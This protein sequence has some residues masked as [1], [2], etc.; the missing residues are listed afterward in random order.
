MKQLK[1]WNKIKDWCDENNPVSRLDRYIIGKFLGD[2]PR[3]YEAAMGAC[4]LEG[5]I[6]E[7]DPETGK[8]ISAEAVRVR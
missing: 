6:F 1:S 5:A 7:I 3:R 8:C 4:K 2:P